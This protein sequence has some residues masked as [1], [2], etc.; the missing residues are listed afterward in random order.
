MLCIT[1]YCHYPIT[2][3]I[4]RLIEEGNPTAIIGPIIFGVIYTV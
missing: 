2:R 3:S 4:S 1:V